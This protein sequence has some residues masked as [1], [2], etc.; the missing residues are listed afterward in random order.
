MLW[1][2]ELKCNLNYLYIIYVFSYLYM[3]LSASRGM[4]VANDSN[5]LII[6]LTKM[7]ITMKIIHL[8]LSILLA[9]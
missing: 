4:C 9:F 1:H 8:L 2:M 6:V 7:L 5:I 3:Y